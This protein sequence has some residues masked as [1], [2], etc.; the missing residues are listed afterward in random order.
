MF[1]LHGVTFEVEPAVPFLIE[2]LATLAA[3][4]VD[5]RRSPLRYVDR[6]ACLD[7]LGTQRCDECCGIR[8]VIAFGTVC[9][10]FGLVQI[11]FGK[12]HGQAVRHDAQ[13]FG[14]CMF[15]VEFVTA[16]RASAVIGSRP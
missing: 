1:R 13:P 11:D 9:K 15:A 16:S 12:T 4:R 3:D 7:T 10:R 8:F 14:R 2:F 5:Q 6:T